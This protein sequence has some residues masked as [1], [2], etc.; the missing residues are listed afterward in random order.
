MKKT[1]DATS[2]AHGSPMMALQ[3]K[4]GSSH[5]ILASPGFFDLWIYIYIYIKSDKDVLDRSFS[6]LHFV[7]QYDS[8]FF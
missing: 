7:I 1:T 3:T 4:K 2:S 8:T 5:A 6:I